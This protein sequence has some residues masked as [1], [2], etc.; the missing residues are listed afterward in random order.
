MDQRKSIFISYAR[1]DSVIANKI[2]NDLIKEGFEPWLDTE[3]ILLGQEWPSETLKKLKESDYVLILL[4]NNSLSKNG[5]VHKEIRIALDRLDEFP[6]GSI[7]ILPI[8]LDSCKP[9]YEKLNDLNRVDLFP[10]YENGI[11]KIIS[12]LH[13]IQKC[14]PD[15]INDTKK[16]VDLNVELKNN[17]PMRQKIIG[18]RNIKHT[19]VRQENYNFPDFSKMMIFRTGTKIHSF[20]LAIFGLLLLLSLVVI[21]YSL[22]TRYEFDLMWNIILFIGIFAIING[23]LPNIEKYEDKYHVSQEFKFDFILLL[24]L[25]ILSL[26][27][28]SLSSGLCAYYLNGYNIYSIVYGI[29]GSIKWIIIHGI[30]TGC[31]V[32]MCYYMVYYSLSRLTSFDI[33]NDDKILLYK[34]TVLSGLLAGIIFTPLGTVQWYVGQIVENPINEILIKNIISIS[35]AAILAAFISHYFLFTITNL[36]IRIKF[37]EIIEPICGIIAFL[38]ITVKIVHSVGN[39][40]EEYKSVLLIFIIFQYVVLFVSLYHFTFIL[41]NFF[42]K[43]N[44]QININF[45]N[46]NN[47]NSPVFINYAIEDKEW[48]EKLYSDLTKRGI[49]VWMDSYSILPGQHWRDEIKNAI[50]SC[51]YFIAMLSSNSLT[52]KG[53]VNA[54]LKQAIEVLD[55]YPKDQSFIIPVRIDNCNPRDEI[56][57]DIQWVDMFPNWK[58]GLEKLLLSIQSDVIREGKKS[59]ETA[60]RK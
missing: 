5:F 39:L 42:K 58:I 30:I 20:L 18:E 23:F 3:N 29:I 16:D 15:E 57:L 45:M 36:K 38:V 25:V 52:K 13:N 14:S 22:G 33:N 41:I 53:Y 56:L 17:K 7:Y 2:Y 49:K 34:F 6:P 59:F 47:I 21:K 54:E 55:E 35:S 4:S 31:V 8:R 27:T 48:A 50:K 40:N 44:N 51:R 28:N 1:E 12:H 60:T 9:S 32:A 11:K 24:K 10:S 37:L 26:F 43:T 46:R 19:L